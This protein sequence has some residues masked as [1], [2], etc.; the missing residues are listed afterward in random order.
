MLARCM[1][2]TVSIVGAGRVGISLGKHLR[3]LGW[4]IGAVVTRSKTTARAAVRAIGGGTPYANPAKPGGPVEAWGFSL[5]KSGHLIRT[6]AQGSDVILITTP[7]DIMPAVAQS[8]ADAALAA[9]RASLR[10]KVVLH[11]SA[12]LNRSAL[13][14][15][16]RLGASTGSLH[17]M[18]AFGGKVVPKLKGVIFGI[19]GDAKTCRMAQSL[20]K[21][22]GGIPVVIETADKPAYHAAAVMA[23]GSIYPILEAGLE[24]LMSIGFTRQ[25]A[26]QTL[27]PLLRQILDNIERIGPRAAWTGPLSRGDYAVVAKHMEALRRYP[28]EF[29]KSY[30]ALAQLAARVLSKDPAATSKHLERALKT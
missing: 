10:G 23:G 29:R 30:A 17:P 14:P 5:A 11:T 27:L 13:A 1:A 4:H 18:Q 15:L 22:L 9:G 28:P 12:T 20:A 8:L 26:S 24:L 3:E 2:R 7:D 6:L 25:R 16:A 19:E 21:S